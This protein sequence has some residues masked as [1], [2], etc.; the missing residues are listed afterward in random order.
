M[1]KLEKISFWL[2]LAV[3]TAVLCACGPQEDTTSG[4]SSDV[5][6]K[7][8]ESN[9]LVLP[10]TTEYIG[11]SGEKV[12]LDEGQYKEHSTETNNWGPEVQALQNRLIELGY[13]TGQGNASG[14]FEDT[15][16][17][18]VEKFE[19]N[20]GRTPT[21]VA[22]ELMQYYLFSDD[23]RLFYSSPPTPTPT[24]TPAVTAVATY[25]YLQR[26]DSGDDVTRLQQRLYELGYLD[27]VS[28]VYDW[29]TEIA[30]SQFA[31]AYGHDTNGNATVDMQRQLFSSNAKTYSEMLASATPT[32]TATPTPDPYAGF[33]ELRE[34]DKGDDVKRLQN[35]LRELDYM[36]TTADGIYGDRTVTA[37]KKF[38]AAYRREQTGIATV[39]MQMHLFADDALR[40]GEYLPISETT[41]T[42]TPT[43]TPASTYSTLSIGSKGE[44][45]YWL[46]MRLIELGYLSGD[47]DGDFGNKTYLA[48]LEFEKVNGGTPQGVA[49]AALQ[50]Y[51]FSDSAIPAPTKAP[52]ATPTGYADLSLGMSGQAVV[53]LQN[54]LSQLGYFSGAITGYFD[55]ATEEAVKRFEY[56]YGRTMTGIASSGLQSVLFSSGAKSY[57]TPTPAPTTYY[58][59][60]KK[61]DRGDDVSRL[62]QRLVALG[63]LSGTVDGY[64]GEGTEQ[65]VKYF[66]EAY[67]RTATGVA[68]VELQ[69]ILYSSS[70]KA[71]KSGNTAVSYSTLKSGDS[72]AAVKNLQNRL[73]EL[74]YMSSGSASGKFDNR[75]VNA[76]KS[77][78]KLMGYT[79]NGTA[80]AELQQKLFS[81]GAKGYS[82][83]KTVSVNRPA[84]V[85]SESTGVYASYYDETP[86]TTVKRGTTFTVLQTRGIWAKVQHANGNVGFVLFS[87][88]E[89]VSATPTPTLAP[90]AKPSPTPTS[91][92]RVSVNKPAV[93]SV[94]S[95]TVYQSA[96]TGSKKLG[97]LYQGQA[98]VWVA[99]IGEWAEIR[100]DSGSV[101]GYVKTS[102]LT[103]SSSGNIGGYETLKKNS[104]G[105]GV[106]NIQSR[107]KELGYYYGDIGGNYKDRTESAVKSFQS[108][109]GLKEDGVATPGL[110]DIL[111]SPYAPKHGTYS[112]TQNSY[113][114]MYKGRSD[115][116]VTKLQNRLI[117]L[118]YLS[119]ASGTYD[120]ATVKAVKQ[121]QT[122]LG[123]KDSSG[124]ATKEL[125]AFLYKAGDVIR[126]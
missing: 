113:T 110:Q 50:K 115:A 4:V 55:S 74:G 11:W 21:G 73:I 66:E 68:T 53:N 108:E 85:R 69:N 54:R 12:T 37:V 32:P 5:E 43:P 49:T 76:V 83:E 27:Y 25:R 2:L 90:T 95:A 72:G 62:Q 100:N 18:A 40:Y 125:Q 3:L 71:N 101:T 96:S 97:T 47:A 114:D 64:F 120:D 20:Y 123:L 13:W 24:A 19:A 7:F 59:T 31:S 44:A 116:A 94:S 70:A 78:Q 86:I 124:Y 38:E 10:T 126:K 6:V 22:T 1:R 42:P 88:I 15:T 99:T 119:K 23:A 14:R 112:R 82:S 81:S 111:F 46:Q 35:R 33:R 61:G 56:A 8:S 51:L 45:V 48:L 30:V 84:Q 36:H 93:I 77:F 79:V 17:K 75:T 89:Y 102:Q 67:S 107:L 122:A 41:A 103:L 118:G 109:I 121:V 80:S 28:S 9:K 117:E 60:L 98:L 105:Q 57:A 34:G 16:K 92:N 39:E 52:T 63:Y 106:K 29:S 65:A 58:P 91:A 26:G 87:D 104:T